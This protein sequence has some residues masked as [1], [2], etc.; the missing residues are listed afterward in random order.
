MTI[1]DGLS[2]GKMSIKEASKAVV[3]LQDVCTVCVCGVCVCVC[4]CVCGVCVCVCVCVCV[5]CVYVL[6]HMCV[7]GWCD[8]GN[9]YI[10]ILCNSLS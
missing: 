1:S 7:L 8:N 9:S 4:V 10:M 2:S 6:V 3:K 5:V